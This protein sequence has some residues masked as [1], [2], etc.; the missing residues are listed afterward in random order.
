MDKDTALRR[1]MLSTPQKYLGADG[2]NR[3]C[4]LITDID[5]K[6]GACVHIEPIILPSFKTD[7]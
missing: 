5:T 1:F 4:G 6:T 3:I 7:V 2:D